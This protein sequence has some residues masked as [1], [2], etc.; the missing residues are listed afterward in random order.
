MRVS[1][2]LLVFEIVAFLVFAV[3][4]GAGFLAWRLSQGPINLEFIRPQVERSL[5]EARGGRPVELE[6]LVLEWSRRSGRVEAAARQLVAK[7]DAGRVEFQAERAVISLDAGALLSGKFKTRRMRLENG[8]A[9]VDR[10]KD[11]VW[12][13]ASIVVL[14]EPKAGA[15]PFDPVKDLNWNTLA[16]PIRAGIDAGSFERVELV[17]FRMDVRDKKTDSNW[18]AQPVTGLWRSGA[19]GVSLSL[20]MRLAEEAG[21]NRVRI[22]LES[23]GPVSEAKGEFA[24]EGVNPV[25][26]ARMMGFGSVVTFDK[27]ANLTISAEATEAGGLQSSRIQLSDVA[28]GFRAGALDVKV[29]DLALAA[30]YDPETR[31]V[32]VESLSIAS[33][34]LTGEFTGMVDLNAMMAA[35]AARDTPFSLKS[36]PATLNLMPVFERPWPF[37]SI[38]LEGVLAD[39][40]LKLVVDR[41]EAQSGQLKAAASGEV[42]VAGEPG[43]RKIGLKLQAEGTGSATPQQVTDFWPVHVGS[44]ARDWVKT[45]ITAGQATRAVFRVDWPPGANDGGFLPDEHLSLDFW[46]KDA[47]IGYLEGFPP[48]T[49]AVG[50]GHLKG[51]SLSIDISQGQVRDW[52]VDEGKVTIPRFA[53]AGETLR[54]TA[55]GH[56]DLK[57]LMQALNETPLRVGDAYGLD[58]AGMEGTGGVDV[59]ILQPIMERGK[60]APIRYTISGRFRDAALPDIAAGFGLSRSNVS[61]EVTEKA[62]VVGGAGRF[63]SAPAVFE[64][65]ETLPAKP[66][67]TGSSQLTASAKVTPDVLNTLGIAARNF[68]QGEADVVLNASGKGRDFHAFEA[69]LD[70]T[71]AS[72]EAPEFGWR[73]A[74]DSPATGVLRYGR[75][76]GGGAVMTA[77]M[78][79][80]GL[81]LA[82]EARFEPS[83]SMRSAR[84]ERIFAR[85]SIDLRGTVTQRPNGGYAIALNGPLF[86]V[87]P[88][89]DGL[90]NMSG[91]SAPA[92]EGPGGAGGDEHPANEGA[93][94]ITLAAD[95]LRVRDDADLTDVKL[96]TNINPFG[97]QRADISGVIS[98]G[99]YLRVAMRPDGQSQKVQLTSDD[100]GFA[101][102]VLLKTDYFTGGALSF[103]GSFRGGRGDARLAMTDVRIREAPLLAQ[104]LS[105]ASLRGLTDILNGDG[106]LFTRIDAPL[107]MT[108]GRVE[109]PGLRASGPAMGLTSR[110]WFEPK[111]GELS[112]DGVLVPS[113]GV[114]SALGGLPVIGDLFVS[115]QGE[116]LF[117]PIYSVRGDL[118]AAR[119]SINPIAAITPGVLRRIFENPAEVPVT[120][121]AG[122]GLNAN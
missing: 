46:V 35:G 43:A 115:R 76:A 121:D 16:T 15:K 34:R 94:D 105:V 27:P 71:H 80:V 12:S 107:R 22:S 87:R 11:G 18:S 47:T 73:K 7:D 113:F 101:A 69:K 64:W 70:L 20:D 32:N 26:F 111:S 19:D 21:A 74:F 10:S 37:E 118:S 42:W 40:G 62:L 119:V 48:V 57:P 44:Q 17:D 92:A 110:G 3:L 65:K 33:D 109:L 60:D 30:A 104:L 79:G 53:P 59:E 85:D 122:G 93:F 96:S 82:G 56:G 66:G 8:R 112:L 117:A 116:G 77:D 25:V 103:D 41:L 45:N 84:I 95:R 100:A 67:E 5:S 49:G 72:I 108:G 86:D 4:A 63:G 81:A 90:L 36:G 51:N 106:V 23:D 99:K 52:I 50:V 14:R 97:P 54:V 29:E 39:G 61:V 89:M 6:S 91:S 55:S 75:D 24:L 9:T 78:E 83:G 13:L 38:D 58:I 68:M 31:R 98:P 2:R 88:W 1:P 102:K 28:G 120:A 114:N